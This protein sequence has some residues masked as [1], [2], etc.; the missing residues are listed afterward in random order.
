M[1]FG[2]MVL[3]RQVADTRAAARIGEAAGFDWMGVAD[4]PTV[5]EDS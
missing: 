3:P 1:R 2:F 4:S 5:Y